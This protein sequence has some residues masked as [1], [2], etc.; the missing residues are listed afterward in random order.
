M[1]KAI[2]F[3][4]DYTL[5]DSTDG[6]VLSV[7]YALENLGLSQK[8]REDIKKTIGLS[9]KDTY[10]ALTS[11]TDVS[12][13]EKF[14]KY[15][16][17]KADVVMVEN[18]VIYDGVKEIL[19]ELKSDGYKIGIVTTKYRYRIEKILNRFQA[20]DLVDLIVGSDD[21]KIEKPN[22]EGLLWAIDTLQL[23]KDEV[24]YVGDS[25]VDAKTAEN[26]EV[27]FAGV[28]TGTTTKNDFAKYK[29]VFIGEN[30]QAVYGY[31]RGINN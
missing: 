14:S 5:G 8:N 11:K 28:L 12:E 7:N 6:I 31:I 22:P 26:A 2:I 29:N 3:D 19:R 27:D 16:V 30:M 25:V 9:L 17:E 18:T 15:F 4:F 1:L 21:V 10:F 13:A 24:L 20:A 23:E